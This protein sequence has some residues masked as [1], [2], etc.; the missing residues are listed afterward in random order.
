VG[1]GLGLHQ[2]GGQPGHPA[3]GYTSYLLPADPAAY[4]SQIYAVLHQAEASGC[5]RILI[6]LP[7]D[8]PAW[9]HVRD[10]LLRASTPV[11]DQACRR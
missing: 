6:E 3:A 11:A 9:L 8:T 5:S 7:P 1:G 4:A 2:H 10:R